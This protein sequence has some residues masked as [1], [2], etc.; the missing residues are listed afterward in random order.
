MAYQ[1][2]YRRYRPQRFSDF[3]GQE[4]IVR[5][6]SAQVMSGR[7]AHAYLFCGTRGTGK[8]SAAKV[9]ARAI[10]CEHPEK[11]D[12]C[13][14][15]ETCRALSGEGSLDILEIDAASNNGVDEIRELRENVKY[16]PRN[17]RYRVYIIDEVHMLSAGAFNALLK[18]LEEPPAHA[19][20]ILATTEPQKLPATILSR[21]Q[22]FDFARIPR[23][24]IAARLASAMEEN[25]IP[26]EAAALDRI[27]RAAEGG[28]RDAWSITD[29]CLG[30]AEESEAGLTD[31]LVRD[32]LGAADSEFLF[33][34]A[35]AMLSGD[36]A[37]VLSRIDE[38]MRA[39]REAQVLLR[40]I[41]RHIRSLLLA[42]VCGEGAADV[43]E[44]TREEAEAYRRQAAM[45]SREKLIRLSEIFLGAEA[46]L[47]W[48][49]QPRFALET[50]ALRASV[51]ESRE[52]AAALALRVAE[53][54]RRLESGPARPREAAG[55]AAVPMQ[56]PAPDAAA[57]A[58]PPPK[59]RQTRAAPA[60]AAAAARTRA[61]E[62]SAI[63]AAD[64]PMDSA[65]VW[66]KA[67]SAL[68]RQPMLFG[69]LQSGRF[70]SER[71]GLFTAAFDRATGGIHISMLNS[72]E[73]NAA[74]AEALSAAAGRPCRFAAVPEGGEA[75]YAPGGDEKK[76]AQ[77]NLG[78]IS[79]FFG[80]ENVRVMR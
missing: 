71:D 56:R 36:G 3:V 50:A 37:R 49:A 67:M 74:V 45:A 78:K 68:R 7:I 51:P 43:L 22:R 63:P 32:V 79:D 14:T 13:G 62:D 10:N 69:L 54:E 57:A 21:C 29:M 2:L 4:A 25:G 52:D 18:T 66:K 8:T 28:M 27:A 6:L 11:G 46:D 72:K 73:Q 64:A 5:T 23:E 55:E 38:A 77:E 33:S 59:E 31:E 53:L 34:L 61:E 1:A 17:G 40:D 58:E 41:S 65:A 48:S 39:G 60:A 35:E 26:F 9:F 47:K 80:R 76:R 12:P 19:K 16:P 20:F 75:E 42:E 30:Y 44:A 15:C 70:V 24:K